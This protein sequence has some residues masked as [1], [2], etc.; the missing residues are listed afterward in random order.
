LFAL[1][2]F[3]TTTLARVKNQNSKAQVDSIDY[4]SHDNKIGCI[5]NLNSNLFD[6]SGLTTDPSN[7]DEAYRVRFEDK[8]GLSVAEF[9]FC[10]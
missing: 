9:N 8:Y 2:T 4:K 6:L 1:L 7:P 3:S 5:L 10:E